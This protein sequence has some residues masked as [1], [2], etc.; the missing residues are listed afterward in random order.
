MFSHIFKAFHLCDVVS[1]PMLF[2][3]HRFSNISYILK[4][5]SIHAV[6]SADALHFA[7]FGEFCYENSLLKEA[8][9]TE[10]KTGG[11]EE[12]CLGMKKIKNL[13]EFS[14]HWSKKSQQYWYVVSE[15]LD[16]SILPC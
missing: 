1:S 7:I 11:A 3:C 12:F 10:N 9:S 4:N 16:P 5:L 8:F 15:Q 6:M 13:M 14:D 2:K